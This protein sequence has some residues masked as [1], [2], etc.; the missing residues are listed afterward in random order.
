[1]KIKSCERLNVQ[2]VFV[3]GVMLLSRLY[4]PVQV[5]SQRL[6]SVPNSRWEY[7]VQSMPLD[8]VANACHHSYHRW[9]VERIAS[10]VQQTQS[11]NWGS[12]LHRPPNEHVCRVDE[13]PSDLHPRQNRT[14][15]SVGF[16][17]WWRH[18]F[19]H[20]VAWRIDPRC[21]S[22]AGPS[23]IGWG[24]KW[25]CYYC[26]SCCNAPST[27]WLKATRW[28]FH[29]SRHRQHVCWTFAAREDRQ[30]R[31]TEVEEENLMGRSNRRRWLNLMS[32]KKRRSSDCI[33]FF[34]FKSSPTRAVYLT[35][36]VFQY[37]PSKK[38]NDLC[39]FEGQ[40]RRETCVHTDHVWLFVIIVAVIVGRCHLFVDYEN[41]RARRLEIRSSLNQHR[42][43]GWTWMTVR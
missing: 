28:T 27:V 16:P 22:T 41:E 25:S 33:S 32:T 38:R 1:M 3:V 42:P 19:S 29:C 10:S 36:T 34:S 20:L 2:S 9:H 14:E 6:P 17:R 30:R 7:S 40:W 12:L 24:N 11:S 39:L 43:P 5:L 8:N 18:L 15:E 26:C 4:S 21:V 13:N 37:W 23:R 35:F 31:E